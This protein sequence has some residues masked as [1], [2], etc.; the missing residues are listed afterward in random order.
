MGTENDRSGG[1][2]TGAPGPQVR[3]HARPNRSARLPADMGLPRITRRARRREAGQSLVELSLVLPILLFIGLIVGDFGRIYASGVAVES[4]AREAADYAAFDDLAESHFEEPVPGAVPLVIDAKDSTRQ[5]A[6]RRACA[7]V[8]TLPGYDQVAVHCADPT[9]RC[10]AAPGSFCQLVV[11]DNR[12]S[13]PFA[14]TCGIDPVQSD[15]TCGWVVHVT[16]TYDFDTILGVAPLPSSVT[17]ARESQFAISAL[18][19]GTP[20]GP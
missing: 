19:G 3:I 11:V 12:T 8:S 13:A 2:V 9:S 7:A 14:T 10:Q 15:I 4:A 20:P 1:P 6:L 17:L 18:P 5:E 16:V